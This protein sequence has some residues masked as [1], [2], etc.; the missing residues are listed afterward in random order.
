MDM[1]ALYMISFSSCVSVDGAR[2]LGTLNMVRDLE[3]KSV[4]AELTTN[5]NFLDTSLSFPDAD[6]FIGT[7]CR[8]LI[9]HVKNLKRKIAVE[10]EVEDTKGGVRT[11]ICNTAQSVARLLPAY[12]SL[13]LQLTDGWNKIALDLGSLTKACFRAEYKHANRVRIYANCRLRRVFFSDKHYYNA[14]LPSPLQFLNDTNT[15]SLTP[16]VETIHSRLTPHR[17]S[18]SSFAKGSGP[19]NNDTQRS[20]V[21]TAV[22]AN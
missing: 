14:Q 21:S 12:A 2:Q 15:T 8:F 20:N 16:Q 7:P 10:V 13:P 17:P 18:M 11:I 5:G 19:G 3:V 22:R 1:I 9:F 4:C 6:S